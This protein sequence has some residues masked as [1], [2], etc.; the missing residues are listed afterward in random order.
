[1]LTKGNS[2]ETLLEKEIISPDFVIFKGDKSFVFGLRG[3]DID[4]QKNIKNSINT[5]EATIRI[6]EE[7]NL[8]L[9]AGDKFYNF[10]LDPY[11][12]FFS[13]SKFYVGF[14]FID[15]KNHLA[16]NYRR[17]FRVQK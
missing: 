8:V 16:T 15:E 9:Q 10:N 14:D 6:N 7:N 3:L 11:F 13:P 2:M 12:G 17:M 4:N 1:M 5:L